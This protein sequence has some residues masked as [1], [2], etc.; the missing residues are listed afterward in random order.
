MGNGKRISPQGLEKV[1]DNGFLHYHSSAFH[2]AGGLWRL[3]KEWCLVPSR[4]RPA[5]N[6]KVINSFVCLFGSK[7]GKL[8]VEP[9]HSQPKMRR[10]A[11]KLPEF[12]GSW[13]EKRVKSVLEGERLYL[14][15]S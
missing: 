5:V 14:E 6:V 15:H 8:H 4:K 13:G 10:P 9:D 2:A 11:F 3:Q 1:K 7:F 12:K